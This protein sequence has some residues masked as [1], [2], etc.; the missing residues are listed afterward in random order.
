MRRE[1]SGEG[2]DEE[3]ACFQQ[4]LDGLFHLIQHMALFGWEMGRT[5]F[6]T[7]YCSDI[8][9][10]RHEMH[11]IHTI[12]TALADV[13]LDAPKRASLER[14]KRNDTIVPHFSL[15]LFQVDA[16]SVRP[17]LC[18]VRSKL[19]TGTCAHLVL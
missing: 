9:H 6:T 10:T 1:E 3:D 14:G 4:R 16:T 2:V 7:G 15:P 5:V 18:R 17:S 13:E 12:D 8:Q 19:L 11:S